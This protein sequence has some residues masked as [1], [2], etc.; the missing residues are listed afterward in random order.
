MG[1]H[2][3]GALTTRWQVGAEV[4]GEP[5][6]PAQV[7]VVGQRGTQAGLPAAA[8]VLAALLKVG[9]GAQVHGAGREQL[10]GEHAA[11]LPCVGG[12]TQEGQG[13]G[14]EIWFA[15]CPGPS[16]FLAPSPQFRGLLV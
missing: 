15:W 7:G 3:R 1:A 2:V 10:P 16:L 9:H 5:M 4:N 14:A 8:G 12:W 11:G 13:Q 6:A